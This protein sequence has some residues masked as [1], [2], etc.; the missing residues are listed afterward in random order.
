MKSI[1]DYTQNEIIMY[2]NEGL[3]GLSVLD[4]D[5]S[6]YSKNELYIHLANDYGTYFYI[7]EYDLDNLTLDQLIADIKRYNKE[8]GY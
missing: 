1:K 5:L 6:I 2:L 3:K 8:N 7:K 4:F